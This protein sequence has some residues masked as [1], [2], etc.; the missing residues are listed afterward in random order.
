M[1][2]EWLEILSLRQEFGS[3]GLAEEVSVDKVDAHG[4]AE[5]EKLGRLGAQSILC[6]PRDKTIK[7]Y[8]LSDSCQLGRLGQCGLGVHGGNASSVRAVAFLG[9]TGKGIL[10]PVPSVQRSKH[11]ELRVLPIIIE[12]GK[13]LRFVKASMIYCPYPIFKAADADVSRSEPNDGSQSLVSLPYG[14]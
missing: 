2:Q 14:M 1:L 11:D 4:I 3:S 7:E 10:E 9:Q 5:F 12:I 6:N 8:G 13:P